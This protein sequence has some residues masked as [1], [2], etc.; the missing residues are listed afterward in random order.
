MPKLINDRGRKRMTRTGLVVALCAL[1]TAG[2][3]DAQATSGP[4]MNTFQSAYYVCS[5]GKDAFVVQYASPKQVDATINTNTS[6]HYTM[7]ST[8]VT[9]GYMYS[10]GKGVQ[11]WTDGSRVSLTGTAQAYQGCKLQP[12]QAH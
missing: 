9:S 10:N 5:S 8:P 2:M 7:K 6:K 3:A 4:P 11:F 12:N 1:A